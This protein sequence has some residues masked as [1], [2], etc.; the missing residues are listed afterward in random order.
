MT[1]TPELVLDTA[2]FRRWLAAAD[3]LFQREGAR[4]TA[5]D[6]AIGDGDHGAN[7]VRG[8]GAARTAEEQTPSATPG[9]LLGQAGTTLT[10]SVG[11]ASGPLFGMALRRTGKR[12]GSEEAVTVAQFATALRAGAEAVAKLGGA[13]P[14]DATLLDA[15]LPAL[16]TLDLE[17]AA[18]N[19][20]FEALSAARVAA[21]TAAEATEPMQAKKGR[22]S[23]LGERSIGH[24]D[25]G[26]HSVALLFEALTTAADAGW[27][28]AQVAPEA[29]AVDA[30]ETPAAETPV[31]AEAPVATA[32]EAGGRV[33]VVLVSHS[34][35]VAKATAE[36]AKAMVG[37]GDTAP[38]LAAGGT[39]DGRIGTSAEL[40]HAAAL[41]VDE[42][43]GVAV[44]CDMGSAV[45]TV[46]ALLGDGDPRTMPADTRIVDAPFV[47]GAVGVVVTASVGGDLEMVVAAGE[48]A[49]NYRK[50]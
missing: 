31:A 4:L 49:R 13:A 36:L 9:A 40:I 43:K 21:L 1:A 42:G 46:Q 15:L 6:A 22:A 32:P 25:A 14:G 5:L 41:K 27:E 19:A 23:Y 45:L 33:G 38:V 28:P 20:P 47:E 37:S 11:G 2:Y 30:V 3:E 39:D 8:F 16:D 48:D 26:A 10:N 35:A 17:L 44:L 24:Q 12:L 34:R 7:M 29:T 18:G 50:G